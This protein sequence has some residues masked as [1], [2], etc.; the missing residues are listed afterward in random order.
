MKGYRREGTLGDRYHPSTIAQDV[1]SRHSTPTTSRSI[2]RARMLGMVESD[3][4]GQR[5]TTSAVVL[6][7]TYLGKRRATPAA[8]ANTGD[9][10]MWRR[11]GSSGLNPKASGF[12]SRQHPLHLK[13]SRRRPKVA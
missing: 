1:Q 5:M 9:Q 13:A 12:V 8:L 4:C 7:T 3:A 2:E 6:R 10:L 11:H